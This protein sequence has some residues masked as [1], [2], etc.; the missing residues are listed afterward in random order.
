MP[1]PELTQAEESSDTQWQ[2]S[3][4]PQWIWWLAGLLGLVVAALGLVAWLRRRAELRP[5]P[6]IEQPIIVE[7]TTAALAAREQPQFA[8]RFDVQGFTRSMMM[9]TVKFSLQISNRSDIAMRDVRIA[10][11]L[12]SARRQLPMEQQVATT[13]TELAHKAEIERIGPQQSRSITGTLQLPMAEVEP[14]FQGKTPLFVPLARLRVECERVEPQLQTYIVGMGS[15]MTVGKVQPIPLNTP[16]GSI[17][18]IMARAL[19]Q[20]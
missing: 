13:V 16:P 9:V 4:L 18:G 14:F 15:A 2:L 12:V 8:I 17:Q 5:P 1:L 20:A 19:N 3:T 7:P 6:E 11:D 10:A